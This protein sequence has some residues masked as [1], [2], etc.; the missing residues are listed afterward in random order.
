MIRVIIIIVISTLF[1]LQGCE[2]TG[3]HDYVARQPPVEVLAVSAEDVSYCQGN[4]SL[5][6]PSGYAEAIGAANVA[7]DKSSKDRGLNRA[8]IEKCRAYAYFLRD[9]YV[10]SHAL[11]GLAISKAISP[12][13]EEG[14]YKRKFVLIWREIAPK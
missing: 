8:D 1:L 11:E 4:L 3:P 6:T 9:G 13:L 10:P 12:F 7:L 5:Q 2:T 14:K